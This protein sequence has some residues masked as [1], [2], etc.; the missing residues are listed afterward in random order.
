MDAFSGG[1]RGL[2]ICKHHTERSLTCEI[3]VGSCFSFGLMVASCF[4]NAVCNSM[5]FSIFLWSILHV[6]RKYMYTFIV[7]FF[8]SVCKQ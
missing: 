2:V 5:S 1:K 7:G 6:K 8:L 3:V 4:C